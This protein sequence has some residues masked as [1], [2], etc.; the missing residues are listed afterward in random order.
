MAQAFTSRRKLERN[1]G[2]LW[3]GLPAP[4]WLGQGPGSPGQGPVTAPPRRGGR[5]SDSESESRSP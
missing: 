3:P 5:P 1:W 2:D 4:A